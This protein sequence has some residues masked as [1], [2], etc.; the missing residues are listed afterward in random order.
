MR[1]DAATKLEQLSTLRRAAA[2]A[3][4]CSRD[5]SVAK[6]RLTGQAGP[7]IFLR[8]RV[9]DDLS[10]CNAVNIDRDVI[11]PGWSMRITY[12]RKRNDEAVSHLRIGGGR[13]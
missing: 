13:D 2:Q 12:E 11:V 6:A 3:A 9:A 10:L 5:E 1:L 8:S 7:P 4:C